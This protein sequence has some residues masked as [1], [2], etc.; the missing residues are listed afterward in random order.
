MLTFIV[1]L[2]V[3]ILGIAFVLFT[4]MKESK[5]ESFVEEPSVDESSVDEPVDMEMMTLDSLVKKVEEP[6]VDAK[7]EQVE[8]FEEKKIEVP[9]EVFTKAEKKRGFCAILY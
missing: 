9:D 4:M 6:S 3:S 1:L 7:D 8:Q 2:V 5:Q